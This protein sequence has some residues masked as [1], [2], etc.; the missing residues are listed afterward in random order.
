[1]MALND[2]RSA[3]RLYRLFRITVAWAFRESSITT[4]MPRRSDSSRMS[5]MPTRVLS[6]TRPAIFST[7]VALFTWKGNSLTMMR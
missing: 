7:N 1:M 3:V 6:L 5:E 2:D 4:R